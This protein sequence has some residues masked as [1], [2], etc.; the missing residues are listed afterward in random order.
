M[1]QQRKLDAHKKK[2]GLPRSCTQNAALTS[3]ATP[4]PSAPRCQRHASD[5]PV[6]E[7]RRRDTTGLARKKERILKGCQQRWVQRTR[8]RCD[9]YGIGSVCRSIPV[10]SFR[11]WFA[12]L[13]HC[14][15]RLGKRRNLCG[16]LNGTGQVY[17]FE[18]IGLLVVE[19]LRDDLARFEITPLMVA[20]ALSG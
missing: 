8:S 13:G 6:V 20:P 17:R 15:E 19:F 11:S 5:K 12:S 2:R 4:T 10:G 7:R 16:S 3:S 14:L 9:P 18:R 1:V